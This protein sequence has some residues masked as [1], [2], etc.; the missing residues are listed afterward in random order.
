MTRSTVGTVRAVV[1]V[2]RETQLSFLAASLAYYMLV[3]LFP[4]GLLVLVVAAQVGGEAFA[5]AVAGRLEV[6]LSPSAAQLVRTTLLDARGQGGATVVS[7]LLL[8]WSGLR[9]FRGLDVA[10][11][12]VYGGEREGLAEQLKDA[13]AALGGLAVAVGALVLVSSV[14]ARSG[15]SLTNLLGPLALVAALT[16]AFLPLY[17]V[18]P[19]VDVTVREVLPGTLLAAAGWALLGTT[20]SAYTSVASGFAVYGVVG[21][22]LLLVTWFYF[23]SV[24]LLSGAVLNAVLTGRPGDRQL[25]QA[26]VRRLG[27]MT[28]DDAD[29]DGG[30]GDPTGDAGAAGDTTGDAGA[31]AHVDDQVAESVR[32]LRAEFEEFREDVD[33]RTLHRDEVES[34]LRRYVRRRVRR[35][36][37]RGWGPYLVLLYG[38]VMTLGA[39]YF[40]SGGWAIL[41]MIVVWLS[42]LGL[43]TLMVLV[44]VSASALGLPG[45]VIDRVRDR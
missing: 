6:V 16:V 10:F 42:T 19:N 23:A 18:F 14:L 41:A 26:A 32:S 22:V 40:L 29:D 36:H 30:A 1:G 27:A 39:F 7:L 12:L 37:A 35:G 5:T 9:L 20:F 31:A 34:D 45:R 3:S 33:D 21:G 43:Y 38:T 15:I 17:Y 25:Q 13:F 2:V 8:L 44:G 11:S 4:L 24:V 28:A